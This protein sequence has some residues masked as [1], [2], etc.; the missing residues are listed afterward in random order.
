MQGRLVSIVA[1]AGALLLMVAATAGAS[2]APVN[3]G[4]P[5]PGTAKL[6]PIRAADPFG[7]PDFTFATYRSTIYD[8]FSKKTYP[9]WCTAGFRVLHGQ[10]GE[11][12]WATGAFTPTTLDEGLE[13]GGC[14]GGLPETSE[15]SSSI[16]GH[17]V[18]NTSG[19][20]GEGI[21]SVSIQHGNDWKPVDFS[22][23]GAYMV[24]LPGDYT[25]SP[26]AGMKLMPL[27]RI[28]ATLCG[29]HART[30]LLHQ[31]GT[32]KTGKCE[33]TMYTP[34]EGSIG[35]SSHAH[36]GVELPHHHKK[37]HHKKRK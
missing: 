3:P 5:I 1:I 18:T 11:V 16:G 4:D 27:I 12:D 20:L 15:A 19:W 31:G 10:L 32:A 24:V 35:A 28:T 14:G 36:R 13:S 33:A 34:H 7:G 23:D 21:T 2:P 26:V 6:E 17:E 8:S 30:D 9:A 22:T 29:P 25:D 37:P